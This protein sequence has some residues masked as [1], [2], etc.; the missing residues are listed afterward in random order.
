[1]SCSI[2]VEF[3]IDGQKALKEISKKKDM[4]ELL[5]PILGVSVF[6][7]IFARNGPGSVVYKVGT[8]DFQLLTSAMKAT[9]PILIRQIEDIAGRMMILPGLSRGEEDFWRCMYRAM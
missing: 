1:M 2:E 4:A 8:T 3:S 7:D 9:N 5:A 6:I